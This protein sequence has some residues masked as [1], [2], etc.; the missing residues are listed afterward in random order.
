MGRGWGGW[1]VEVG[2]GVGVG[3]GEGVE[4]G[5]ET[6]WSRSEIWLTGGRWTTMV[7]DQNLGSD[8]R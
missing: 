2:R 3:R 1:E 5:G 4:G 6:G 8:S 7:S